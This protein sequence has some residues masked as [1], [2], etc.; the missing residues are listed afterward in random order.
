MKIAATHHVA[1]CTPNFTKLCD[2]YENVLG[3]PRVGRFAG[4]NIIFVQAGDTVIEIVE[5]LEPMDAP[6]RQGWAHFAFEVDDIAAAHAE[7]VGLGVVFHIEPK[8][9]PEDSPAV[10]LAFFKDP[11]GNELELVE[12][13]TIRY[14]QAK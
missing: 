13:L 4:K 6:R 10:K 14:P 5:R 3:L 12:P 7:L 2:F 11:D 1:V 8:L 9:F